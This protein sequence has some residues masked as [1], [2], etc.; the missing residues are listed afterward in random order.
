MRQLKRGVEKK[1]RE[2]QAGIIV[3]GHI[4]GIYQIQGL[5]GYW[6]QIEL[7]DGTTA[8]VPA[9]RWMKKGMRIV[10]RREDSEVL[11]T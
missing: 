8:T 1:L 3:S 7:E 2:S 10:A 9:T 4:A 6:A 11:L 5:P